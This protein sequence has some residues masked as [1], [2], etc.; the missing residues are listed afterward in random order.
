M[1]VLGYSFGTPTDDLTCV[2]ANPGEAKITQVVM[3]KP[4]SVVSACGGKATISGQGVTSGAVPPFEGFPM[5]GPRIAATPTY[6]EATGRCQL[7]IK[8]KP[9]IIDVK[10]SQKCKPSR[11]S[12]SCDPSTHKI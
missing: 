11:L 5:K 6:N 12:Y 7:D 4:H 2:I 1:E 8:L 3:L 10:V 9:T